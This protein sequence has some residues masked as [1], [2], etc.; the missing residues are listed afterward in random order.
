MVRAS[1]VAIAIAAGAAAGQTFFFGEDIGAGSAASIPNTS[2]ARTLFNNSLAGNS[3]EDFESFSAGQ[4]PPLNLA[5]TGSA[6]TINATL[7]GNGRV[8]NTPITGAFA[9]SGTQYLFTQTTGGG[10][11]AQFTIT[12]SQPIA[13]FGFAA[14]DLSDFGAALTLNF[15]GGGGLNVPLPNTVGSGGSTTGSAFFWGVV[16]GTGQDFTSVTFD[17][18]SGPQN[19]TFGFDDMTIGDRSQVVI[20]LPTAAGLAGFGLLAVGTRRRR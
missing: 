15:A 17:I 18:A 20:P 7:S 4:A 2:A 12:F 14:T 3:V 8:E 13:A 11:G 1:I 16:A 19:D 10:T 9:T 6:G 5:F